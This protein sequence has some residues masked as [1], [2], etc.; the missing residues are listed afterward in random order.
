MNK[1]EILNDHIGEDFLNLNFD[2]NKLFKN[3][4]DINQ[5]IFINQDNLNKWLNNYGSDSSI[6]PTI[7]LNNIDFV[8][9]KYLEKYLNKFYFIILTSNIFEIASNFEELEQ[10]AIVEKIMVFL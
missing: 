8:N 3:L 9:F 1:L 4:L 2:K 6:K 5:N 7:I 10:C